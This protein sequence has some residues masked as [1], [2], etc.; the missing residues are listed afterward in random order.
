MTTVLVV[1]KLAGVLITGVSAILALM[2][3]PN[4]AAKLKARKYL[5][6]LAVFGLVIAFAAQV[7]DSWK[8]KLDDDASKARTE[9]LLKA[10]G[11]AVTR[12]DYV[13]ME[14]TVHWPLEDTGLTKYRQRLAKLVELAQGDD[15][16]AG[17]ESHGLR[18]TTRGRDNISIFTLTDN[19][20]AFPVRSD[21]T[22]FSLFYAA[23][24][25]RVSIYKNPPDET[26]LQKFADSGLVQLPVADLTLIP[27]GGKRHSII[28]NQQFEDNPPFTLSDEV[29]ELE[30]PRES[31]AQS[32]QIYST[33]DLDG[34]TGVVSL[35][36]TIDVQHLF[37]P[38]RLTLY[39][40]GQRI[41]FE[42]SQ[43]KSFKGRWATLYLFTFPKEKAP[44]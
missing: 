1:L 39:F 34:V 6:G 14:T 4:S 10:I 42:P 28:V 41:R 38:P 36:S 21:G 29:K 37:G 2:V 44:K 32:G 5:L 7:G 11:R 3:E 17:Q 35:D 43:L 9:R 20:V 15:P 30:V 12:I 22:A 25:P 16:E 26:I 40:N 23:A 19:S 24:H 31:W 18:V 8:T 27:H 13:S 33:S